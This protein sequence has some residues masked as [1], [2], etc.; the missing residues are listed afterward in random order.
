[1]NA[2]TRRNRTLAGPRSGYHGLLTAALALCIHQVRQDPPDLA[3]VLK[4]KSVD[5]LLKVPGLQEQFDAIIEKRIARARKENSGGDTGLSEVE[6]QE[7]EKLRKATAARE[8]Q[9]LE[10]K[11]RYDAII[12]NKD[13]EFGETLKSKDEAYNGLL[14]DYQRAVIDDSL[15][16]EASAAGATNPHVVAKVLKDRVRLDKHRK[17]EVLDADGDP[18]LK[19]GKPLSIKQLMD[20][21]K[22]E[23]PMLF[24]ADADDTG[25]GGSGGKGGKSTNDGGEAG[26]PE[27]LD[28]MEAELKVLEE[29]Q[30]KVREAAQT[31]PSDAN[32][33][34]G[35]ELR[36]K[37]K[38]LKAKIAK[39]KGK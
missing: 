8:Q 33:N 35:I 32:L 3:A 27:S 9:E 21:A 22:T 1:M 18:M 37:I 17:I 5:D 7:L 6:K 20:A 19:G 4:G 28:A 30:K 16:A 10:E 29:D 15:L 31:Q 23:Y 2:T 39:K 24:K 38:E 36:R 34:K 13:K 14:S 11:K 12:A 26:D 25:A